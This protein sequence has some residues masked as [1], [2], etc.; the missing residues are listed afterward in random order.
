MPY[1]NATWWSIGAVDVEAV[2]VG[3]LALVA[4]GRAGEQQDLRVRGHDLAVELDV[5]R[6]PPAL[7]RRRRLVAQQLLDGVRD[8]RGVGRELG[9]L[10]R[11]RGEHD[12]GV[13]E[14][15]RD[16]LGA[17][18]DDQVGEGRRSRSRVSLRTRRRRRR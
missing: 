16:R 14:Q 5:A 3:V 13:A 11:V 7:H 9:A 8:Q 4:A 10:V 18:A 15:A 6:R 12:R 2:G 1:P 17:R